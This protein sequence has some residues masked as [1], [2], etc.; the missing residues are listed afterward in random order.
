MFDLAVLQTSLLLIFCQEQELGSH[1]FWSYSCRRV[2][3]PC[4]CVSS[5]L[6]TSGPSYGSSLPILFCQIIHFSLGLWESHVTSYPFSISFRFSDLF[7]G[8]FLSS[9]L[10]S[11]PDSRCTSCCSFSRVLPSGIIVFLSVFTLSVC[12]GFK[13]LSYSTPVIICPSVPQFS[14]LFLSGKKER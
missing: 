8:V 9:A 2:W 3:L 12:L 4:P 5:Q 11:T 1:N 14:P 6:S 10:C 7:L 13:L